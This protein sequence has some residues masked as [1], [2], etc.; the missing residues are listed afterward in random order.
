MQVDEKNT[1]NERK[2]LGVEVEVVNE[3]PVLGAAQSD[4]F[5]HPSG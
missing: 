2:C 1:V 3:V 5:I 4:P